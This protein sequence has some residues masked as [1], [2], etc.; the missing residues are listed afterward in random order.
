MKL[1]AGDT[2]VSASHDKTIR[3]WDLR[4]GMLVRE[5]LGHDAA[6]YAVAAVP[7]R[8]ILSASSD[9]SLRVFDLADGREFAVLEGHT[10]RVVAVE[11][12]ECL[13]LAASKSWDGTIRLWDIETWKTCALLP[14]ATGYWWKVGMAFDPGSCRLATLDDLDQSVRIWDI[15]R[16]ALLLRLCCCAACGEP[17][18]ERYVEARQK[19][20]IREIRCGV[21]DKRISLSDSSVNE[22]REMLR[23]HED[24][25]GPM[26]LKRQPKTTTR[27]GGKYDAFICYCSDDVDEVTRMNAA[28]RRCG[29]TTWIDSEQLRAGEDIYVFLE[30][31]LRVAQAIVIFF[32]RQTSRRW[33]G[34]E[35]RSALDLYR[36]NKRLVVPVVL[37]GGVLPKWFSAAFGWVVAVD[38]NRTDPKAA[39][40]EIAKGIRGASKAIRRGR[41][42]GQKRR[43]A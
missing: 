33:Q 17:V 23:R 42:Q 19:R 40:D 34:I 28:L 8:R 9:G 6:V 43:R 32:G 1:V 12:L 29:V 18:P 2:I 11:V 14:E 15:N 30:K 35:I 21:C 16:N 24:A 22:Y 31:S 27:K 20:G 38:C 4:S 36:K 13:G 25:V 10:D 7:N 41:R 26:E 39:V 37:K 5:I 3:V